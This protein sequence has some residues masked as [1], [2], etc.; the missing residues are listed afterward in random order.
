VVGLLF[1]PPPPPPPSVLPL[2]SIDPRHES[3]E[4]RIVFLSFFFF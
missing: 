3:E 4:A 1:P 2:R